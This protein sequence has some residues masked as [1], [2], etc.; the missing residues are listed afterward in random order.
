MVKER[1]L[2]KVLC[3]L[4]LCVFA[5]QFLNA[6]DVKYGIVTKSVI[7]LRVHPG[8]ESEMATQALL[9]TP[10][11]LVAADDDWLKVETPEGYLAWGTESSVKIVDKKEYEAWKKASKLIVTDYFTVVRE[12]PAASSPVV[13]DVVMGDLVK[14]LGKS[15]GYYKIEL[16]NGKQAYLKQDLAMPFDKWL[17]S[18]KPTA[19]NIIATARLFTGFPY[20]WGGLSSKGLDCSG[21]TK[22]CYYMN[23]V[24]LLRDAY[25][26]AQTGDS[27]DI[28]TGY[29]NLKPGDLLFFGSKKDGKPKVT[30][31]GL[32]IGN[33]HFIHS[34]GTVHE[35]S[36]LPDSPIYD[37]WN[38]GRLLLARRIIPEIDKDPNIVSIKN[39]SFYK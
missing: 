2:K 4:L 25:Q 10:V 6:E 27:V 12:K 3:T 1:F 17:S 38:A 20:F 29:E 13:A 19:E 36:L 22:N 18:R 28:S 31:V 35:S 21:F 8:F 37:A 33:G 9:G 39:H 14:N 16:P 26:Q 32:Y 5:T 15:K 34:S 7:D 30:H 24:I 23:G 11:Q